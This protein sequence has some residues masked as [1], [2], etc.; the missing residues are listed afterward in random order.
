VEE[1]GRNSHPT[2]PDSSAVQSVSA[3]PVA[4]EEEQERVTDAEGPPDRETIG[5][6]QEGKV[7]WAEAQGRNWPNLPFILF[8]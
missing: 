5:L 4:R 1:G 7:R 2:A 6:A 3:R 8:F